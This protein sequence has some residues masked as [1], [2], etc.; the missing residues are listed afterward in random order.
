MSIR[1]TRPPPG[2]LEVPRPKLLPL[3]LTMWHR[4]SSPVQQGGLGSEDPAP[5]CSKP[6]FRGQHPSCRARIPVD[7][8]VHA[9]LGDRQVAD[10][11]DHEE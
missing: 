8:L 7:E 6:L 3:M 5:H 1:Q 10:F 11:V 4:W 9:T 2:S